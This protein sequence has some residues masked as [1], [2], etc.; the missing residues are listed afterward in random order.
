MSTR[1]YPTLFYSISFEKKK[2]AGPGEHLK[3]LPG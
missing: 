2:T 3:T 1:D